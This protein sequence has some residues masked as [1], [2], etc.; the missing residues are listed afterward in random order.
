MTAHHIKCVKPVFNLLVERRKTAEVRFNDRFYQTGDSL[1]IYEGLDWDKGLNG[2]LKPK[3]VP[4][5]TSQLEPR[6]IMADILSVI[7]GGQ[8]GIEAGYV[9][10]S[11]DEE[12]EVKSYNEYS[13]VADSLS[14]IIEG[15]YEYDDDSKR[16]TFPRPKQNEG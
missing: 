5:N 7:N 2:T 13:K 1:I 10:L 15:S 16:Y 4:P 9:L 3:G 8:F 12:F 14:K 6:V 11:L